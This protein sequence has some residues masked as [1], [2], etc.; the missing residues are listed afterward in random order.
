MNNRGGGGRH[1]HAEVVARM[2]V[3]RA[4]LCAATVV[5]VLLGE[6]C[7]G[8]AAPTSPSLQPLP[9]SAE[10]PSYRFHYSAG[11]SV[12]T[13]W[14]EAYHAW[15]IARLGVQVPQKIDYYK[16][17]TRQDMGD[18]TGKYNTNGFAEP[19]KFEIHTLWS[20]DNHE[21]VHIYTAL[22]DVHPTFSTRGSPSRSRPT[23]RQATLTQCSTGNPCTRPA[24]SIS[25]PVRSR[26]RSNAWSR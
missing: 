7:G 18:H 17:R 24:G 2:H 5:L 21:V 23:R 1:V 20:T 9:V 25:R 16:Y 13:S 3:Q 8:A 6:S 4:Y 26:C 11:D 12:H 15:A 14:Q 19:A 10:T 22:T